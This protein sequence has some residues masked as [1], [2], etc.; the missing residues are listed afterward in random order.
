MPVWFTLCR[1]Q[2]T[3]SNHFTCPHSWAIGRTGTDKAILMKAMG[4][5]FVLRVKKEKNLRD[6]KLLGFRLKKNSDGLC[7]RFESISAQSCCAWV[8][9]LAWFIDW[10]GWS[11][12]S[13]ISVTLLCSGCELGR[14]GATFVKFNCWWILIF[15]YWDS[16]I[17]K[18]NCMPLLQMGHQFSCTLSL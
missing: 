13:F 15:E 8:K 10:K 11:K 6:Q 1:V 18:Q 5:Y 9:L 7:S 4:L 16:A 14:A 17:T 2:F 3:D 12:L